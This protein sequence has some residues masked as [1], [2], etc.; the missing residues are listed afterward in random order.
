MIDPMGSFERIK[1]NFLLV[2]K[3]A[4]GT[5]YESVEKERDDLLRRPGVFR[6]EPWIEPR[7]LYT[8]VKPI[9]KIGSADVPG[10]APETISEFTELAS[11]GLVGGYDLFSH[12][13]EMLRK[14]VSGQN[15]VVTAGTGS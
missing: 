15:V 14:A 4:F 1:N 13:L 8:T 6:Q 11:C 2:I 9:T 7:P 3:T 12:Q 5:Q 10:L